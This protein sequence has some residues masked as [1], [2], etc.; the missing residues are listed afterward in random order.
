MYQ[1]PVQFASR[2]LLALIAKLIY[3]F[4]VFSVHLFMGQVIRSDLK[5]RL[6]LIRSV[7]KK[8]LHSKMGLRKKLSPF[9]I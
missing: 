7:W 1:M 9:K 6:K 2:L 8:I 3:D 4:N 5:V